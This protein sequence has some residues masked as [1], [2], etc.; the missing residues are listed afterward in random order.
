MQFNLPLD[1]MW[2]SKILTKNPIFSDK[3]QT[4]LTL[5]TCYE[6]VMKGWKGEGGIYEQHTGG[7]KRCRKSECFDCCQ[8]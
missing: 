8:L 4:I 7:K 2:Q 5:H 3:I 1:Q 6:E